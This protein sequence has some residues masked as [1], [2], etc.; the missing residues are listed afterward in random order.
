MAGM[1]K[2]LGALE[3]AEDLWG[4]AVLANKEE[5][6]GFAAQLHREAHFS[7]P[8]IAK[9][10]RLPARYIYEEFRPNGGKGGRFDPESLS[11][12]VVI[13]RN[14]VKGLPIADAL[15]RGGILSGTSYT[16]LTALTR[17]PYSKYYEVARQVA[18]PEKGFT[19]AVKVSDQQ[20]KNV[21]GLREKGLN[22]YEI[23]HATGLDQPLVSRILRGLR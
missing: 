11:T 10:V 17:I 16:C 18:A 6:M 5:K 14:H 9:I 8:Q 13:R 19:P 21:L 22:Q 12:L 1:D 3:L 4:K 15:I 20:R 7:L 23:A 2:V